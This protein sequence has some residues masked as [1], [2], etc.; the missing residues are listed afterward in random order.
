MTYYD[1]ASS[2]SRNVQA[3]MDE[4]YLLYVASDNGL[5]LM[6]NVYTSNNSNDRVYIPPQNIRCELPNGMIILCEGFMYPGY[7]YRIEAVD[8]SNHFWVEVRCLD[9]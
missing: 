4:N 6:I 3:M 7:V 1:A 5:R 2:V 9:D 8:Q